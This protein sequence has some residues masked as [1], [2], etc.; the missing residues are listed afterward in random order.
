M[1]LQ[2]KKASY[3]ID[4]NDEGRETEDKPR[5]NSNA[6]S[7]IVVTDEGMETEVMPLQ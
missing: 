1:F 6:E 3:P 7:P 4:V 2:L 5:Q